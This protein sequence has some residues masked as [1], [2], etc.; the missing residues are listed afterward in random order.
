MSFNLVT[1]RKGE[2]HVTS[3]Q[4]RD[5][6]R[7]IAGKETYIPDVNDKLEITQT[8][9]STITVSSG[10]LIHHGCVFEIPYG[11]SVTLSIDTPTEGVNKAYK[12]C[13]DWSVSDGI[14]TGVLEIVPASE[15]GLNEGN[16]QEGDNHD[17]VVI[18]DV[19][20][21]GLTVT[22]T[23]VDFSDHVL[24][25]GSKQTVNFTAA[26]GA[27][28]QTEVIS[29][30]TFTLKDGHVY[31]VDIWME[32][33]G[34]GSGEHTADLPIVHYSLRDTQRS[35]NLWTYRF[36]GPNPDQNAQCTPIIDMRGAGLDRDV[37]L[38]MYNGTGNTYYSLSPVINA[39][40]YELF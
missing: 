27:G 4:F 14:E 17:N 29:E 13:V 36:Y 22:V 18:A 37:H 39:T 7:A 28:G 6:I 31:L 34:G 33:A 21:N 20:V 30:D 23:P 38:R 16:M 11:D 9:A 8:T 15:S 3:T 40:V 1:G 32:I 2:E 10:V 5:I 26:I 19:A 35:V 25:L 12:I 24:R